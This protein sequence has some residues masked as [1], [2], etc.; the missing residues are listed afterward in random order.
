MAFRSKQWHSSCDLR[1]LTKAKE[2]FAE[3]G[4]K[5]QDMKKY[6]VVAHETWLFRRTFQDVFSHQQSF[7]TRLRGGS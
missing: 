1:G 2:E 6:M 7:C 5:W 3:L 4:R